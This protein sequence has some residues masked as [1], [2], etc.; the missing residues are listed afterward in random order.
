MK[1]FWGF[2]SKSSDLLIFN[3]QSEPQFPVWPCRDVIT[4]CQSLWFIMSRIY[5]FSDFVPFGLLQKFGPKSLVWTQHTSQLWN[6]ASLSN[7]SKRFWYPWMQSTQ[8]KS[9]IIWWI[10]SYLLGGT[11]ESFDTSIAKISKQLDRN[12]ASY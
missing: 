8:M 9:V 6:L 4:I 10:A 2:C 3:W 7:V 11:K 1:N 12:C 5:F